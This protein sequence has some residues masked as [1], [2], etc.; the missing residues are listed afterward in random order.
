MEKI[1]HQL[2]VYPHSSLPPFSPGLDYTD[3]HW[4]HCVVESL[5]AP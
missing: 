1:S 2:V 4:A 3:E 5:A